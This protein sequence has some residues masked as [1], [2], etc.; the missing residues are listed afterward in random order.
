MKLFFTREASKDLNEL[1]PKNRKRIGNLLRRFALGHD[2]ID[3]KKLKSS[4]DEWRIRTG[5]YRVVLRFESDDEVFV[6]QI[7]HR[8]DVYR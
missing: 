3:I 1:D 7:K 4:N 2:N 8:K 5:K 6:L